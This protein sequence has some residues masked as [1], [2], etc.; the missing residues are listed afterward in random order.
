MIVRLLQHVVRVS[1]V[2]EHGVR[3]HFPR[4]DLRVKLCVPTHMLLNVFINKFHDDHR[5][6]FTF[7]LDFTM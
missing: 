7:H 4:V 6:H 2:T 1:L 5:F 3:F